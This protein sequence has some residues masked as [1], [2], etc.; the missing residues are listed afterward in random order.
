MVRALN[1]SPS[2]TSFPPLLICRFQPRIFLI[3]G[4]ATVF[5]GLILPFIL[6][7]FPETAKF[8]TKDEKEFYSKRIKADYHVGADEGNQFKW[9]FLRA[10]LFDLKIWLGFLVSLANGITGYG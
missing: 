7:D 5:L 1:M 9:K 10:A 8:M 2:F 6:I 3:E 4:L